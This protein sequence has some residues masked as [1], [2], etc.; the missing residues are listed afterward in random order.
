LQEEIKREL[1]L[2]RLFGDLVQFL[3]LA[4][5]KTA[6]ALLRALAEALDCGNRFVEN[7][8]RRGAGISRSARRNNRG[9][10]RRGGRGIFRLAGRIGAAISM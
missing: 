8:L 9:G 6:D 5:K 2:L 10:R 1:R 3:A 7:G 4:G